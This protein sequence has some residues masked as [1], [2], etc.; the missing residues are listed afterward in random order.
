M[1]NLKI[2]VLA[3]AALG[4]AG[5]FLPLS[6]GLSWWGRRAGPDPASVYFVIG[7]FA[8]AL[9]MGVFA[10]ANGLQRWVSLV[11]LIGFAFVVLK[12]RLE[13]FSLFTNQVGGLLIGAG[14]ALGVVCAALGAWRPESAK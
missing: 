8:V 7:A 14:A 10:L 13:F 12:F 5:A 1:R 9:G 2:G 11:A 3:A 4:I 6:G